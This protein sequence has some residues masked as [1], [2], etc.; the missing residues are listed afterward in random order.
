[1]MAWAL[2]ASSSAL[3]AEMMECA[4]FYQSRWHTLTGLFAGALPA[5]SQRNAMM[6]KIMVLRF[7]VYLLL[8]YL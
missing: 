4:A 3:K 5:S 6:M 7:M 1:M 8:W 2:K